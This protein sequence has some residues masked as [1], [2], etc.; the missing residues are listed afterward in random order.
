MSIDEVEAEL[1]SLFQGF[2]SAAVKAA[3]ESCGLTLKGF[4]WKLEEVLGE[5]DNISHKLAIECNKIAA[6]TFRSLFDHAEQR[7]EYE[8]ALEAFCEPYRLAGKR[9]AES[10]NNRRIAEYN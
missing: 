9:V 2:K 7:I 8:E 10:I 3:S 5:A 4:G 1:R 6:E